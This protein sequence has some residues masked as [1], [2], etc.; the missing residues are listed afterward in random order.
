VEDDSEG[1]QEK[2]MGGRRMGGMGWRIAVSAIAIPAWIIFILLYAFLWSGSY[3]DFQNWVI[4]IVSLMVV[5][6]GVGLA[7]G[8]MGW[9]YRGMM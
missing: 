7:W 6:L 5:F 8:S 9:R 4:L 1:W 3:T 2:K